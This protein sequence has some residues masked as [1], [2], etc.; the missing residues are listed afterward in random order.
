[1]PFVTVYH[2]GLLRGEQETLRELLPGVVSQALHIENVTEAH[3]VPDDIRVKFVMG[4][5]EDVRHASRFGV[6]ISAKYFPERAEIL[7][8]AKETIKRAIQAAI[9]PSDWFYLWVGLSE[10]VYAEGHG[11]L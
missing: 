10:G 7:E 5:E 6:E 1:M 3:L 9:N 8:E 2:W 4:S 11:D